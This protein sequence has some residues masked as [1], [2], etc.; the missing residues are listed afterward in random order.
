MSFLDRLADRFA[1]LSGGPKFTRPSTPAPIVDEK[2][3]TDADAQQPVTDK[4]AD[5]PVPSAPAP[6]TGQKWKTPVRT[7]G[8]F[9]GP[10]PQEMVLMKFKTL[11]ERKK[12]KGAKRSITLTVGQGHEGVWVYGGTG[13]G[14]TSGSGVHVA[15]AML[16]AGYG[17]IVLC[18]KAEETYAWIKYAQACGRADDLIVFSDRKPNPEKPDPRDAYIPTEGVGFNFLAYELKNAEGSPA[19][20][21]TDVL[22]VLLGADAMKSNDEIWNKATRKLINMCVLACGLAGVPVTL[23]R[24]NDIALDIE[25]AKAV[26]EAAYARKAKKPSELTESEADDLDVVAK[27][28]ALEWG[29]MDKGPKTSIVMNFGTIL[30]PFL[31][32]VMRNLFT[33]TS[34]QTPDLILEEGKIVIVDLPVATH[35]DAGRAANIAWKYCTQRAVR[36]EMRT[37]KDRPVFLFGDEAQS[38][39]T[40]KDSEFATI[41]R[42]YKCTSVYL[43]QNRANIL[44]RMTKDQVDSLMGNFQ[45]KI[46]HQQ[47]EKDT[48]EWAAETIGK[49][50]TERESRGS[51][52]QVG[53]GANQG[54]GS[55][56]KSESMEYQLPPQKFQI[57]RKGGPASQFVVTAWLYQGGTK[58][59]ANNNKT[60][61]RITFHQKDIE[62]HPQ[63]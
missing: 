26:M 9:D 40:A 28:L 4:Q 38:F 35:D 20:A 10:W 62:T 2:E 49:A 8:R 15:Y 48:N 45:T 22:M 33:R 50:M 11:D 32:G 13:S 6:A 30:D 7:S 51:S 57:S 37:E 14:K 59:E 60:F 63:D 23:Q 34:H 25:V 47:S 46:F 16:K 3:V 36:R 42:G 55:T 41:A 12:T 43:T 53:G 24:V 27:Y 61:A 39:I 19:Q 31:T 1:A 54:S 21:A 17:G 44:K 58:Y 18:D 52:Y 29:K 56:N 5:A